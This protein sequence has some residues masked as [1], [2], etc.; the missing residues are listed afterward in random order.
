VEI[1]QATLKDR[2]TFLSLWKDLMLEQAKA[3]SNIKVCDDNILAYLSLFQSYIAGSLFG[4]TLLAIEDGKP[5]G[6]GMGGEL[7]PSGFYLQTTDGRTITTWGVYV[8]PEYRRR[9][10]A[11]ALQDEAHI[12]ARRLGFDTV[13]SSLVVGDPVSEANALNWG[14]KVTEHIISFPLGT[15]EDNQ[16]AT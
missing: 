9:G 14:L 3:G 6:I 12:Q 16:G 5:V 7:P 15:S 2:P 11:K 10:I 1:R 13:I 4:F 8:L